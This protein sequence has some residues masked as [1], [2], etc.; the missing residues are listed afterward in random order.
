MEFTGL[1]GGIMV[2]LAAG[3]WLVY[4]MPSMF[5]RREYVSVE[6]TEVRR[7]QAMRV[8]Q[9]TAPI[10]AV[11]R[12]K[13]IVSAAGEVADREKLAEAITRS[14]EAQVAR[15]AG[16]K[17]AKAGSGPAREA[18]RKRTLRRLRRTRAAA[19]LLLLASLVTIVV[20]A[21]LM[22]SSGIAVGAWGVLGFAA[23]IGVVAVAALGRLAS[24]SR[25]HSI[26]PAAADVVA[27]P[28]VIMDPVI[29]QRQVVE[30]P[31]ITSWT[32]VA[33]PK[34]VYLSR[35]EAPTAPALD[36]VAQLRAAALESD[37][38]LREAQDSPEVTPI[39]QVADSRFASMGI[40]DAPDVVTP[41]LDEV[42]RRR[43]RTA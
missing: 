20:Q 31:V 13:A 9:E 36:V 22:I 12:A 21:S 19:T 7:Q 2:V 43:R 23:V 30:A 29:E 25:R 38:A 17:F 26:I 28:V 11:V 35:S 4:L 27:D 32:P 15:E 40:V 14:R 5:K 3:L 24:M 37:R 42:L 34:P 39:T 41:D 8:L 18:A 16:R 6:R 33:I 10:P 1:G